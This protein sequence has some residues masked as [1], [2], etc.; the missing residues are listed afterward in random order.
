MQDQES[1]DKI[2]LWKYIIHIILLHSQYSI[3]KEKKHLQKNH[4]PTFFFD[5]SK[6]FNRA[7][8]RSTQNNKLASSRAF[9]M[10]KLISFFAQGNSFWII[11][12]SNLNF[13]RNLLYSDNLSASEIPWSVFPSLL[14]NE[15]LL[16]SVP[17]NSCAKDF[18]FLLNKCV[19]T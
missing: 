13:T 16:K 10:C 7:V 4:F 17:N 5:S 19:I 15:P 12:S 18:F 2:L 9:C 1:L 8:S 14:V 11:P 6:H 3:P